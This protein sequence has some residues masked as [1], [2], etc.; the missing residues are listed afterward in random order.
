MMRNRH[1]GYWQPCGLRC[2]MRACQEGP[3]GPMSR[4]RKLESTSKFP[5]SRITLGPRSG[6]EYDRAPALL[7]M[8]VFVKYDPLGG[9]EVDV[10]GTVAVVTGGSGG[11]GG[12]ICRALSKAGANVVVVY[13]KSQVKAERL[14]TELSAQGPRAIALQADVTTPEGIALL[15]SVPLEAFGRIDILV[16]DAASN[17]GGPFKDLQGLDLEMWT[18]LLDIN[19]TAPYMTMRAL[20]DTLRL[21]GKGRIVNISSWVGVVP[22]GSSIGYSVSKAALMH[23]TKCMAVALAPD[24]LVNCIAPGHMEGTAATE[25]LS[26]EHQ[27][28]ARAASVLG[29]PTEKEDVAD[30]VLMMVRTDS[31]TGQTLLVDS[32]RAFG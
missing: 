26:P 7:P 25:N 24:V 20:A 10:A 5:G 29:R 32:G 4:R 9:V 17:I 16:N 6:A 12:C 3:V 15:A 22:R 14:A 23:L 2:R 1:G 19:L 27:A 18:R 13:S 21:N 31:I 28:T 11:L 8:A 30:A